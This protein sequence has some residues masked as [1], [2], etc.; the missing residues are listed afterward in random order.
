[1]SDTEP[2][3][4][5]GKH[6]FLFLTSCFVIRVV[7]YVVREL[8]PYGTGDKDL[9]PNLSRLPIGDYFVHDSSPLDIRLTDFTRINVAPITWSR[10]DTTPLE[11][12]VENTGKTRNATLP[13]VLY[14]VFFSSSIFQYRKTVD[15]RIITHEFIPSSNTPICLCSKFQNAVRHSKRR[16]GVLRTK[17]VVEPSS[18]AV[19]IRVLV[20]SFPLG[21]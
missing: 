7:L 5:T 20:F 8:G 3:P 21:R 14:I 10:A 2:D 4:S 17:A 12:T 6:G 11:M 13:P 16:R 18:V 19:S 9:N 1:M 15:V